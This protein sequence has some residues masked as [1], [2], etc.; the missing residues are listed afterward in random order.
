MTFPPRHGHSPRR[1]HGLNHI[2]DLF[3]ARNPAGSP[4][5]HDQAG[6]RTILPRP[7]GPYS[8]Q[9]SARG[10]T[11]ELRDASGTLLTSK[12][13]APAPT[14]MQSYLRI[15][16]LNY[17]PTAPTPAESAALPGV[18]AS[19]FE[20]IELMNIGPNPLTLTGAQF[21][22]GITFTFPAF[23]LAPGALPG[24]R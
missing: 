18:I 13:W 23:T 21:T 14:P 10:E 12:S 3:V 6:Q 19:D 11:L 4:A 7:Q 2:G 9:L 22:Q 17:S 24:R 16:E 5:A 1:R 15:T 8:G 20:F